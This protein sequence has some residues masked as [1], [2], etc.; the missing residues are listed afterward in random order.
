VSAQSSYGDLGVWR[1]QRVLIVDDDAGVCRLLGRL[2]QEEGFVAMEANGGQMAL[3]M[4]ASEPDI[5]LLITDI[6]MRGMNGVDLAAKLK[7]GRAKLPILFTSGFS[8]QQM[9]TRYNL[10]AD[11]EFIEK[12]WLPADVKEIALRLIGPKDPNIA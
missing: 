3:D 4:A 2:L 1:R 12:P 7:E 10:P 5:A 6:V 11:A 8:K 9:S